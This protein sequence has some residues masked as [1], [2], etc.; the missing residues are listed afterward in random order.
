MKIS[1]IFFSI[2]GE[3]IYMGL[4]SIFVRLYGCNLD[5][6]WCDTGY[7][8]GSRES[9]GIVEHQKSKTEDQLSEENGY[10]E[11]S[12]AEVLE[13]LG[14]YPCLRVCITGGEPLSNSNLNTLITALLQRNYRVLVETNGSL[15]VHRLVKLP[16]SVAMDIKT[17]S[18]GMMDKMNFRNITLLRKRDMLKFVIAN[19]EDFA[20]AKAILQ[21]SPSHARVI[22]TP[23]GGQKLRWLVEKVLENGLNVR[24]LPQLHKIVFPEK[25][26]GV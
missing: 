3:G 22:F 10:I 12:L 6:S 5:C 20:Y 9:S 19:E 17:P 18:S 7:A 26:R 23:E 14:A 21:K 4:P 13:Q 11:M 25:N 1:E 16:L 24:V 8:R 15:S 2:Q